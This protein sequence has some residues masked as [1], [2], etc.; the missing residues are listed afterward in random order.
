[1]TEN[2][3]LEEIALA[4]SAKLTSQGIPHALGGAL[5]YNY[6]GTPRATGDIDINVFLPMDRAGEALATLGDLGV[7]I[8]DSEARRQLAREWQTRLRWKG[9]YIDLF[10]AYH[11][12][13]D[14]CQ[15]RAVRFPFGDSEVPVLTPEDLLVFKA[16]FNRSR[17]W[18]DIEQVLETLGDRFD[19]PYCVRWL[20]EILGPDDSRIARLISLYSRAPG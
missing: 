13:H 5:A 9:R 19:L 20:E 4:V 18:G 14:A 16:I 8:H 3:E 6:Y 1:M 10:F 12:F 2:S 15:A 7:D 17:D 11:P